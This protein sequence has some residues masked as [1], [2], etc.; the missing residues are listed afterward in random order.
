MI[1]LKYLIKQKRDILLN[2]FALYRFTNH[3][4]SRHYF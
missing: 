2:F 4:P 3:K 1:L